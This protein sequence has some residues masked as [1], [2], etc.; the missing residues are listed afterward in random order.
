MTNLRYSCGNRMALYSY[1]KDCPHSKPCH[2]VF[3][4]ALDKALVV[5]NKYIGAITNKYL[6]CASNRNVKAVIYYEL[7]KP[8]FYKHIINDDAVRFSRH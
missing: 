6:A 2:I 5:A 4:F 1:T 8:L 7:L 3:L